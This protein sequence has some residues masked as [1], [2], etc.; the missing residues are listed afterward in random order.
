MAD[1]DKE[2]GYT[3]GYVMAVKTAHGPDKP[4][5]WWSSDMEFS[6]LKGAKSASTWYGHLKGYEDTNTVK[7]FYGDNI[8]MMPAFDWTL[9]DFSLPAPTSSSGWFLPS[10]G[11]LWDMMAN[12][13]GHDVAVHLKEWQ[14]FGYDATWYCSEKVGYDALALFNSVM[15]QI[16]IAEKDEMVINDAS[17]PFCSLWSS[18][19]Y[20]DE[21]ACIFNLGTDGLI[22]C[23]ADWYDADCY[24]RPILAF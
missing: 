19:P 12:F 4:T 14:T 22:E 5:T 23:M 17:H 13:G 15:A 7:E 9:N 16:P 8:A 24:A 21:S 18:T 10:T 6:S 11:Q 1:A 3:H 2:L 20:D